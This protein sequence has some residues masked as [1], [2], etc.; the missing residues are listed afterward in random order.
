MK[1]GVIYTDSEAGIEMT[2]SE[3]SKRQA[4]YTQR[5][6]L[7]NDNPNLFISKTRLSIRNLT[8]N[9]DDATLKF[10]ARL[11]VERFWMEVGMPLIKKSNNPIIFFE[12][13]MGKEMV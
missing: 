11:G 9:V 5:K 12:Q 2:P 3:M 7:L 8:R 1:E 4:S 13:I 6:K 10:V